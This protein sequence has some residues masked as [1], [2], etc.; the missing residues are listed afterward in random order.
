[1]GI[2]VIVG[3]VA[4]VGVAAL[5]G[6]A[7]IDEEA[8]ETLSETEATLLDPA[9]PRPSTTAVVVASTAPATASSEPGEPAASGTSSAPPASEPT[10]TAATTTTLSLVER[11]GINVKVLNAGAAAGA[12]ASMT[13]AVRDAGFTAE[14][15]ADAASLTGATMVLY[16]PGQQGAGA[17]VNVVVGAPPANVV[18]ATGSDPNWATLGAALDVLVVLGPSTG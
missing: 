11:A 8:S 2:G 12:A 18:E 1:M 4:L 9:A 7:L 6:L 10:T 17:A 16:A 15:P 5:I 13:E 14:G 3:G